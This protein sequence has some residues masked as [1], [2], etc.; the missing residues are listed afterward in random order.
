[1]ADPLSNYASN[2]LFNYVLQSPFILFSLI[3]GVSIFALYFHQTKY[4]KSSDWT[5]RLIFGLSMGFFI[6]GVLDM[7]VLPVTILL[8]EIGAGFLDTLVYYPLPII[9]LSYLFL[10]RY[11]TIGAPLSSEKAKYYFNN[12]LRFHRTYW[13]ML[14]IVVSIA[15]FVLGSLSAVFTQYLDIDAITVFSFGFFLFFINYLII[16][17][18]MLILIFVAQMSFFS[19]DLKATKLVFNCCFHTF[20]TEKIDALKIIEEQARKEK[21]LLNRKFRIK[22]RDFFQKLSLI[23]LFLIVFFCV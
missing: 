7:A 8:N 22:N 20:N 4:W 13:I 11:E 3:I 16:G 2:L 21:P 1:M 6:I 23:I 14:M 15:L 17:S 12:L 5:R 18:Y 9:L 10:L 19:I